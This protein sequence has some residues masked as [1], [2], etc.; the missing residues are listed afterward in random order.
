MKKDKGS[1]GELMTSG[2]C[3][4]AM[5]FVMITYMDYVG[6]VEDKMEVGQLARKYILRMET[7]GGLEQ[8]DKENLMLELSALGVTEVD[9]AG[10]TMGEA[11][12]GEVIELHIHGKLK[13]EYE[14]EEYRCSTAKN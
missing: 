7:V 5:T 9:F 13:G 10:T 14:F 4:L 6:M 8:E 2:L 11:G 3:I 1:I 12:Y